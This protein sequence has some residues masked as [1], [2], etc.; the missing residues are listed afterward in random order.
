MQTEID[1]LGPP[2]TGV[3]LVFLWVIS[4]PVTSELVLLRL[5]CEVPGD[6]VNVGSGCPRV[7]I[8]LLREI[9]V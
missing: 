2:A 6:S 5:P 3:N 1:G 8:I 7:S 4:M 9:K